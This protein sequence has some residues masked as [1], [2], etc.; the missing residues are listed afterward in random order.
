[1]IQRPGAYGIPPLFDL[2]VGGGV[3]VVVLAIL[4]Q[5]VLLPVQGTGTAVGG[6]HLDW[7][8]MNM[9]H[10]NMIYIYICIYIYM[11]LFSIN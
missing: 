7:E 11:R 5:L 3:V 4:V 10:R 9:R 1:M 6:Y 2:Q 8:T